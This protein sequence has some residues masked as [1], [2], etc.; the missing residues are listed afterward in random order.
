MKGGVDFNHWFASSYPCAWLAWQ[1][2]LT[3]KKLKIEEYVP[4]PVHPWQVYYFTFI[5][6]NLLSRYIK[7]KTIVFL[8]DVKVTSSPT[9]SFRTLLPKNEN[10][11]AYIKL[12]VAVQA[13]SA[14][15]TLS[16]VSTL[17]VPKISLTLQAIL[18]KEK[19]FFR[20]F[21]CFA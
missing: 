6:P 8:E 21:K 19:L 1:E 12:L 5:E 7:A 4:F 3:K 9:L 15:R 14:F 17:N 20:T 10:N 18:E 11:P 13:T 2:S 16:A